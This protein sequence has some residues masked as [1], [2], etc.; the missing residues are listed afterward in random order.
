MATQPPSPEV[1]SANSAFDRATGAKPPSPETLK[2]FAE[3]TAKGK[4]RTPTRDEWNTMSL[5][6]AHALIQKLRAC[7]EEGAGIL[8]QRIYDAARKENKYTC[9]VCGK[10]KPMAIDDHPNYVW[11]DD[12]QDPQTK[13]YTSRIIC[14]SE[15]YFRGA[16]SGKM[17]NRGVP[18]DERK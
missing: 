11:R 13:L 1:S 7:Y 5:D 9:M 4:W 8:N 2:K 12:R 3:E 14:S 10:K 6:D 17:T 15:C 16:N 18:A